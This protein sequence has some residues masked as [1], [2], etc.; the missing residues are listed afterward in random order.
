MSLPEVGDLQN[1]DTNVGVQRALRYVSP[2]EGKRQ[3]VAHCYLHP[4]LQDGKHIQLHVLVESQ[5]VRV[6][7]EGSRAYGVEYTPNPDNHPGNYLGKAVS[8]KVTARKMVI[9]SCGALSTPLVL[10]RSGIGCPEV[11]GRA[12]VPLVT[13][14]PGVGRHYQDHPLLMYPY[15]SNLAPDDTL[16]ALAGGRLDLRQAIKP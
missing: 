5:V 9:V 2:D 8:K 1:L 12:N 3:D 16:D 11:L 15:K 4:R 14:L 7:F 13:A 10:E 6:L